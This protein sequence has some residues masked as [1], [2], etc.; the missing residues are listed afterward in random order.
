MASELLVLLGF[1][2]LIV[3]HRSIGEK[4]WMAFALG[5]I[6]GL[7]LAIGAGITFDA[8]LPM[9]VLT[10]LAGLSVA[11]SLSLP[12]PVAHLVSAA[13]GFL[14]G[15]VSLADPGP[16][17]AMAFTTSG[18]LFGANILFFLIAAGLLGLKEKLNWPWIPIA[19]RVTGSWI[20]AVSLLLAAL[21]FHEKI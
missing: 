9:L 14:V 15:Y 12:P 4:L 10:V 19:F 16:L 13:I 21:I 3:Q 1:S 18:A 17:A 6:L 11:G 2:L 7:G 8:N 5:N 20:A